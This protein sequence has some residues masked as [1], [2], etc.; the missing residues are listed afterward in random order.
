MAAEP[1]MIHE[2]FDRP[3]AKRRPVRRRRRF[4]SVSALS[5]LDCSVEDYSGF[6]GYGESGFDSGEGA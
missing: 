6:Y 3:A 5:T 4:E 1:A 2:N